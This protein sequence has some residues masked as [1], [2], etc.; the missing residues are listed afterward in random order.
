MSGRNSFPP[1]LA[2]TSFP[3]R[4]RHD[5]SAVYSTPLPADGSPASMRS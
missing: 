3:S 1:A 5:E 4:M 2:L